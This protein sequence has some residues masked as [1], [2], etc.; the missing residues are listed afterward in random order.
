MNFRLIVSMALLAAGGGRSFGQLSEEQM[1]QFEK[2]DRQIMRLS[3]SAFPELP[4]NLIHA[5]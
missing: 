4:A 3:P 5:L 1:R 2:A